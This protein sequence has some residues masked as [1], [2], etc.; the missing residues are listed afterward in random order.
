LEDSLFRKT[1]TSERE[2][3][4]NNAKVKELSREDISRSAPAHVQE[5]N[6]SHGT[7]TTYEIVAV[8]KPNKRV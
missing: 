4:R 8:C 3:I 6:F 5:R 1:A 2:P 7:A